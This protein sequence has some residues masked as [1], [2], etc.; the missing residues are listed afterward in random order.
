MK[1][2]LRLSLIFVFQMTG[3]DSMDAKWIKASNGLTAP[4]VHTLISSGHTLY[5]GSYTCFS[6]TN[7]GQSWNAL[8]AGLV[9]VDVYALAVNGSSIYAGTSQGVYVSTNN[10]Q[11]WARKV[12]GLTNTVVK[13]LLVNSGKIFVGTET[14]GIFLST[15]NGD[16]WIPLQSTSVSYAQRMIKG[17]AVSGIT[18]FA[19]TAGG[20]LRSSNGTGTWTT[21]NTGLPA[22]E[23]TSLVVSE[24]ILCTGTTKG[25]F[26]SND[27]GDN[28]TPA[29]NTPAMMIETLFSSGKH[30][31]AVTYADGLFISTDKGTSWTP[32]NLG[33]PVAYA[34][35][36]AIAMVDSFVFVGTSDG[37]Y[38]RS[39]SEMLTVVPPN[40]PEL[41]SPAD[42]ASGLPTSLLLTWE[43][44][45]GATSYHI[46]VA[47][48]ETFQS[49]T[50]NRDTIHATT[51]AIQY[52][53]NYSRYF[54]RV[55]AVNSSEYSG[56][57]AGRSFTTALASPTL[58]S[59][60]NNAT[61]LETSMISFSW[62]A[63]EG[64]T[65][66]RLQVSTD[67]SFLKNA[68]DVTVKPPAVPWVSYTVTGLIKNTIYYWRVK[69]ASGE[70]VS[71][72]SK[73]WKFETRYA[74][75]SQVELVDPPD[76]YITV[77]D[78]V[79]LVWRPATPGITYYEVELSGGIPLTGIQTAD[80]AITYHYPANTIVSAPIAWRVRARNSST[81]IGDYSLSRAFTRS[82]TAVAEQEELP[83]KF[84][85]SNAYPNPCNPS[86]T[87]A[88]ELPA[89]GFV[90]LKIFNA[91]GTVVASII[92]GELNCG[93]YSCEWNA[94]E[95]PSGVYFYR[96]TAGNHTETK[97]LMLLK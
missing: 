20:V 53:R 35:V 80:T 24:S 34:D 4:F 23:P 85:L 72:W 37:I 14:G 56:W 59:P 83:K 40:K 42:Q 78:S 73:V 68:V 92:D 43:P 49:Q 45:N 41:V 63:S 79:N 75:P 95:M 74:K 17:F 32:V 5:A 54:W 71:P 33:L 8:N 57:S 96:L 69:A 39:L 77:T 46:Q 1:L 81:Y 27:N 12:T 62:E 10:G 88:F 38:K 6:S 70:N 18:I 94:A 31:F 67:S 19:C 30:L 58:S 16:S 13:A 9:N 61:G 47:T 28:W 44:V 64:G 97:R 90:T 60:A 55:R 22:V 29:N 11:S 50:V 86:T 7:Q 87:I 21:A 65:S 66:Y 26:L 93:R 76:G 89:S 3:I 52:L 2:F 84:A 15:N 48:E 36:H 91:L 82:A 51:F 25:L